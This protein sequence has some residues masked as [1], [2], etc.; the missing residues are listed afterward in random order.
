MGDTAFFAVDA[1]TADLREARAACW[2]RNFDTHQLYAT[3]TLKNVYPSVYMASYGA[4]V[5]NPLS[6]LPSTSDGSGR[7]LD[8][9]GHLEGKD[10]LGTV[11]RGFAA[12]A[13][14]L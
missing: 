10:L 3:A 4:L 2:A 9:A 11:R 14:L 6:S 5:W 1:S 13:G 7:H 8:Y 12:L